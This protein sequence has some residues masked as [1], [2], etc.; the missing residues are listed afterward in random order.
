MIKYMVSAVF[1]VFMFAAS[2]VSVG[3]VKAESVTTIFINADGSVSGTNAIQR[4][5]NR[6]DRQR[7][8]TTHP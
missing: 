1:L 8:S 7:A 2:L 6:Y 3:S 4:E 5:G